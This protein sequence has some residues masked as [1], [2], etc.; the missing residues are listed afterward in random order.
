MNEPVSERLLPDAR[1]PHYQY[2]RAVGIPV[3]PEQL[4]ERRD[5]GR[6]QEN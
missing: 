5:S 3:T 1:G 2:G 4:V 6:D